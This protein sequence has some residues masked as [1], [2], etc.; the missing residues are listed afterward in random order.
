[1]I[2]SN[3]VSN[4]ISF[5]I[6]G[7]QVYF[8]THYSPFR[9]L[10]LEGAMNQ[11][12]TNPDTTPNNPMPANIITAAIILSFSGCWILVTI[13]NCCHGCNRPPKGILSGV[14]ATTKTLFYLKD[15][16]Y[17]Q[18][19]S[20]ELLLGVLQSSQFGRDDPLQKRPIFFLLERLAKLDQCEGF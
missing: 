6:E 13:P 12:A 9:H 7:C 11:E 10:L 1:M 19:K 8:Y 17:F 2:S 20:A 16:R 18:E 15:L 3:L 4:R 5:A 14:D